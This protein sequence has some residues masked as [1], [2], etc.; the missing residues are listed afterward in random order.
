MGVE[1]AFSIASRPTGHDG[2]R[3]PVGEIAQQIGIDQQPF[4]PVETGRL[5]RALVDGLESIGDIVDVG[6][7]P[8]A[9]EEPA[10]ECPVVVGIATRFGGVDLGHLQFDSEGRC[11]LHHGSAIRDRLVGKDAV[12]I[13]MECP[14]E[15]AVQY[16]QKNCIACFGTE[17]MKEGTTAFI[18][19]RKAN[20]KG[21]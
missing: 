6:V 2:Q 3:Q 5:I 20:F 14:L 10:G 4:M 9:G 18:E 1:E 12:E 19:K 13:G 11:G 7:D 15:Q 8:V 17:D 16:S 21:K